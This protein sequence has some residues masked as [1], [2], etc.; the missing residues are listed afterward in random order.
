MSSRRVHT[1]A[2]IWFTTTKTGKRRA[3]YYCTFA[4]RAMPYPLA[5]AEL[6]IATGAARETGKPMFVGGRR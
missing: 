2:E 4:F 5:D 6:A 1:P 3:W